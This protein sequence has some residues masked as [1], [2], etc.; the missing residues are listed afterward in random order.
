MTADLVFRNGRI[1][2]ADPARLFVTAV[3]VSRG[4]VAAIG[5]EGEMAD[6]ITGAAEVVDL[7]GRLLTPGFTDAH[8][9]PGQSG[10]DLLRIDFSACSDAEDA[11]ATIAAYVS[12]HPGLEWVVGS[13]W[14]Q[15]WFPR[16]CPDREL[17]DRVV[18]DLPAIIWNTDG[19]SAWVN[20]RALEL[21]GVE[22]TT[23]DPTDGRIER[24]PDNSPQG[25]LHEGAVDLVERHAPPDGLADVEAG[26]VRG[27]QE[28]LSRGITGWQD[29]HVDEKT[30]S[31]YINLAASGRLFGRV[32]GA[33]WWEDS[34]GLEQ[35]GE[36]VARRAEAAPGFR[37]IAVK[38]MLDGVAENFTAAML[39]PYLGADGAPTGNRGLDFIDP[40]VLAE[41]VTLLDHAGFQCHFHAI[42]DR[43]VR[44]ALDAVEAARSANGPSGNRH[45]I[46]HIQVIHP[47]DLARFAPLAVVANAQAF[48][49]C[50]DHYQE[51][52][53]IPFIGEE[54]ASWQYPFASLLA[55]GARLAMGSDWGVSTCDVMEQVAVAVTRVGEGGVPL[56]P[57]EAITPLQAL[58]AFSSGSAYVNHAESEVG[59]LTVGKLADLVVYDR[60]P[61]EDGSFGGAEVET[62]LVGGERVYVA[63]VA[64][65]G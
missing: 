13:G 47:D 22:A 7:E 57:V 46:A 60:D 41:V 15:S 59:S 32:V 5:D 2:T 49:A 61:W 36:L 3:A 18:P 29:A 50:R 40:R 11:L 28:L 26:L 42:G 21:A 65:S 19:H 58:T 56:N 39:D 44:N 4:R 54:R 16:G 6:V 43:A 35:V 25:T 31:A 1:F 38:L 12:T 17:L 30:Q 52:L 48:W 64:G 20:S 37:P 55:A 14:S 34:R 23:P 10:L 63:G 62:T 53:T 8:V 33:M 27:Q 45:H 24:R 9:H 51:E